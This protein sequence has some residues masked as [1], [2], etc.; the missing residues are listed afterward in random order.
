MFCTA[1]IRV[2]GLEIKI[3]EEDKRSITASGIHQAS[4]EELELSR[5][6][7]ANSI[8]TIAAVLDC[9]NYMEGQA[10]KTA[11]PSTLNG[12]YFYFYFLF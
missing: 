1:R 7:S 3:K 10:G 8:L 11:Y 6:S 4:W 12:V 2:K 5:Q 9:Y